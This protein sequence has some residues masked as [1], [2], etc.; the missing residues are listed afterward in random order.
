MNL[1]DDSCASPN[2]VEFVRCESRTS[3][4][5]REKSVRFSGSGYDTQV[6]WAIMLSVVLHLQ[7]TSIGL[8]LVLMLTK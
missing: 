6:S 1:S 8:G 5:A 2:G 3:V 4:S 7:L